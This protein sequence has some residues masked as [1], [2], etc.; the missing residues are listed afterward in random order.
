[1]SE[2]LIEAWERAKKE[3]DPHTAW[4]IG[5]VMVKAIRRLEEENLHLKHGHDTVEEALLDGLVDRGETRPCDPIQNR[6]E[7][8]QRA[9]ELIIHL[10]RWRPVSDLKDHS[11][12]VVYARRKNDRTWHVGIAYWTASQHWNP[13]MQSVENPRGFDWWKPLGDPPQGQ[14]Q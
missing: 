6:R 2:E 5:D 14:A 4:Q 12:P 1:M 11:E 13:E 10:T 9:M 7:R 3:F 8:A